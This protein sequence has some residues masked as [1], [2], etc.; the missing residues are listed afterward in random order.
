MVIFY[1]YLSLPEGIIQEGLPIKWCHTMRFTWLGL[2]F[3]PFSWSN[4]PKMTTH[5]SSLFKCC[6]NHPFWHGKSMIYGIF[7]R[8]STPNLRW[9]NGKN[10]VY[11]VQ[12]SCF[13]MET[14]Q[15][16]RKSHDFTSF[17]SFTIQKMV[18]FP[19]RFAAAFH[20]SWKRVQE[21]VARAQEAADEG[22]C[23][24]ELASEE[25]WF[26]SMG[27]IVYNYIIYI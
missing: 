27:C 1:S 14:S 2:V 3:L 22:V 23:H 7:H 26:R 6:L 19:T 17:T 24:I 13:P 16:I 11:T 12:P 9:S 18:T 10:H 5:V 20:A 8:V 25:P 15:K 21:I 4:N